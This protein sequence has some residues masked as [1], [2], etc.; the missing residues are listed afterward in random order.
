M[1]KI[2]VAFSFFLSVNAIAQT[3]ETEL[4][5]VTVTASLVEKPVSR[6]GRNII[7]IKGEEFLNLP[8][9]SVDE[10][11]RY[12]P[13]V[14]VQMR[15]PMGSQSDIVLRG[16]TFQQVLVILDGVRLNDPNTGHFNSYIPIAPAEI[17]HI[18][19]LKGASSAIYGSEAVGGVIQIITKT[20]A[21]K[22]QQKKWQLQTGVTAGE[23]NL[24]N[25]DI[26]GYY[27]NGNNAIGGGWLSNNTDGQLKRGTRGFVYANT[28][29][30]SATHYFNDKWQLAVRGSYD[31]RRFDA[32]N[33]Y[34]TFASDTANE[35]VSTVWTQA[36]LR[37][38]GRKHTVNV[39]AGWKAVED[40]FQF[41]KLSVANDSKSKILQT[42]ISDEWKINDQSVLVSGA[43]VI[44]KQ[45]R[46]NDR[47]NHDVS[48][49][50]AFL[51]W[52]QSIHD[53]TITPALRLDWNQRSGTELV[54]QINV[55]W[56]YQQF[57][58]RGS[59]GKTIRDADFT[60]R[61]NN[62][63]KTIVSSGQRIGDPDLEAERSFSYEA[64]A[65]YFL[66]KDLKI[67]GTFFQR[68]HK[69][70]IDYVPTAYADMPR[71]DNLVPGGT[72]AL[73]KNI[74]KV[75]TTG[76]EID[77]QYQRT[78]KR[79]NNVAASA[80]LVWLNSTSSDTVPSFYVSSHAKFMTNY[81]VEYSQ[82]VFFIGIN[83]LYKTRSVQ[84]SAAIHA[85][86]TNDYFLMNL[87][88]GGF[89]CKKR[90]KTFVQID[91]LF[92]IKYSDL[93][94]A[95]MPGRWLMAGVNLN[96]GN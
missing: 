72:Y 13:G 80:G 1:K 10:L 11:L 24:V 41:N 47:G 39:D 89:F 87:R 27:Q 7:S 12:L 53:F 50:A 67:S 16:G 79:N 49:A 25:G 58:L 54:P 63:N 71:K 37:Y 48:Q 14:E 69:K 33:F 66:A 88:V 86:I 42:T 77:I 8:V 19:I 31:N 81:S 75:T 36:R 91:N 3:T 4:D 26:G 93:L 45:I 18:E 30:L 40:K 57:Q 51:V 44:D 73:A 82:K 62:Y 32:Q 9:H 84:S 23:H 2:L 17:D 55:S 70:L 22:P 29:S 90:I 74:A 60:E 64:G 83:G 65:D 92:N 38:S 96:L 20:F 76:E 94:G 28:A 68:Y 95:V 46:S 59:A 15:G 5:P 52:N 78:F 34:T 35:D 21:A 43:Q 56:K 85:N 61:Y 6:T